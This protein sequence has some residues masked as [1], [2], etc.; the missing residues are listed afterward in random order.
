MTQ[1]RLHWCGAPWLWPCPEASNGLGPFLPALP[2]N[3]GGQ[4][5]GNPN[6]TPAG[7]AR[8]PPTALTPPPQPLGGLGLSL[9]GGCSGGEQDWDPPLA[10]PNKGLQTNSLCQ[11]L[12][13]ALPPRW[14]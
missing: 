7:G 9:G 2:P 8:P 5:R 1:K 14:P 6:R 4:L 11:G 12:P 13:L 3:L 10:P